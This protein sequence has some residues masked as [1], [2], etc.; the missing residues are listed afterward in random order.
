MTKDE[1]Q[2]D[3]AEKTNVV[4][5]LISNLVH[6]TIAVCRVPEGD[7]D[8]KED[9]EAGFTIA[10]TQLGKFI[11]TLIMDNGNMQL[12]QHLEPANNID[13]KS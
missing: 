7:L 1:I 8:A 10:S 4:N 2:L 3:I 13:Y 12:K 9:A 6:Q 5:T 11:S